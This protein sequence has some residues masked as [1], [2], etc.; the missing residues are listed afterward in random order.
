MNDSASARD[1][2]KTHGRTAR[3]VMTSA[4]ITIG[5]AAT[6]AEIAK[7]L[8]RYRIKRVP[9]VRMAN[10]SASCHEEICSR[11]WRLWRWSHRLGPRTIG[12]FGS[13]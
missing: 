5:E 10:S 3:D 4:V 12:V 7:T 11:A 6:L 13:G 2:A 1:Y 8:E 9:V